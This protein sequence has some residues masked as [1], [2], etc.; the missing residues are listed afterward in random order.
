ME[1][2]TYQVIVG[3]TGEVKQRVWENSFGD[4]YVQSGGTGIN[5]RSEEW[6]IVI[7]GKLL[8]GETLAGVRDFLDRHEGYKPFIWT[9]P[10][11][12]E[13][14]WRATGYSLDPMGANIFRLNTIFKQSFAP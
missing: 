9:S 2:F 14:N 4:G 5:G 11:G 6:S 8:A 7:I 13:G 10:S 1:T 12:I 3:T